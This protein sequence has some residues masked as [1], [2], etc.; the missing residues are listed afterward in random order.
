MRFES[1]VEF[2]LMRSRCEANKEQVCE[3]KRIQTKEKFREAI[4]NILHDFLVGFFSFRLL[5][6]GPKWTEFSSWQFTL[7][8]VQCHR[9]VIS[10]P[11]E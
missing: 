6:I 9:A 8:L 11:S 5:S 3:V 1:Q 10:N 7:A 4:Y 2:L